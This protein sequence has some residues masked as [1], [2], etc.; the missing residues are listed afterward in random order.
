MRALA[1]GCVVL[2]LAGCA[3]KGDPAYPPGYVA[4]EGPAVSAPSRV[5]DPMRRSTL[6]L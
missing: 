4:P 3:R 2:A 6:G 5:S 1:L